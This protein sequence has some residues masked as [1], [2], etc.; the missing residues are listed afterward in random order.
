MV[1]LSTITSLFFYL[2]AALVYAYFSYGEKLGFTWTIKSKI[3]SILG[4][5]FSI[6][7]FFGSGLEAIIWGT[8]G[9]V[10]GVP[11][12]IYNKKQRK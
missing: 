1:L 12:Y 4:L 6:W 9:M 8:V 11:V 5:G 10:L 7:V 2:S 3:I